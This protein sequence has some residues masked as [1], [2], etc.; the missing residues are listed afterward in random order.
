[1]I[2]GDVAYQC[3]FGL[4]CTDQNSVDAP[5]EGEDICGDVRCIVV[6]TCFVDSL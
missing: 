3:G 4:I 2:C 6:I 1:M 5:I